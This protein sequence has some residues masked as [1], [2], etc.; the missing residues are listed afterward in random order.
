M[1]K[2]TSVW[3]MDG[4]CRK[5][6]EAADRVISDGTSL[7]EGSRQV[8]RRRLR[9]TWQGQSRPSWHRRLNTCIHCRYPR[10]GGTVMRQV[11][12]AVITGCCCSCRCRCSL[13]ARWP[14]WVHFLQL[15][16]KPQRGEMDLSMDPIRRRTSCVDRQSTAAAGVGNPE[17]SNG[18]GDGILTA[19]VLAV[20]PWCVA[21]GRR[22]RPRIL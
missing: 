10:R 14:S 15:S 5:V 6:V 16:K 22:R 20:H 8:N 18:R 21:G 1:S 2:S 19:V 12:P 4:C 13:D 3:W 17:P 9:A 11:F 7:Q